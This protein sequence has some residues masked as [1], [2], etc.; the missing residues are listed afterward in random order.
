MALNSSFAGRGEKRLRVTMEAMLAP[1][2]NATAERREKAR[3]ENISAQGARVYA[4]GHWQIGEQVQITPIGERSMRGEVIYCHKLADGRFVVGLQ[5]RHDPVL[6]S[7][8]ERLKGM[9]GR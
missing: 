1:A 6:S 3:V 5:V 9:I 4:S 2:Q 7:I 8:L